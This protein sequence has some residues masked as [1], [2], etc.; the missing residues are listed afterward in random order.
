MPHSILATVTS[1]LLLAMR[2]SL[3]SVEL[4]HPT[5]RIFVTTKYFEVSWAPWIKTPNQPWSYPK[6]VNAVLES[7]KKLRLGYIDLYLLHAPCDA[8]TRD[9]AWRALED[10]Q[11]QGVVRDIGVSNFGEQHLTKLAK[12]WRVKPAVNQVELHMW[13]ADGFRVH[14]GRFPSTGLSAHLRPSKRPMASRTG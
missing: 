11:A 5:R 1:I 12:T 6:V 14:F 2:T 10:M 4:W 9:D 7:N 3:T 13:G 8:A